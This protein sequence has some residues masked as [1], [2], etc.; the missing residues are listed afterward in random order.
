MHKELDSI[1]VKTQ[2][3]PYTNLALHET[4][5]PMVITKGE[6]VFVYDDQG[7]RYLEGLA[8]LRS[9]LPAPIF[10]STG[11]ALGRRMRDLNRGAARSSMAIPGFDR[12]AR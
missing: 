11:P 7:N 1:D 3:H 4:A 9:G 8:G 2:V 12:R 5:G 10:A 6:G